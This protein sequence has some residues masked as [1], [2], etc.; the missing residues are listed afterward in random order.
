MPNEWNL[1]YDQWVIGDG[2]P[3]RRVGE[4]FD[5]F[6]VEF[7]NDEELQVLGDQSKSAIAMPDFQY[8]VVAE[9]VY[10]SE[11]ACVLDFGLR[12][13]G[14][15]SNLISGCRQGD[16]VSGEIGIGIPLCT[17][18]I[19]ENLL[20]TLRYRWRVNRISADVTPYVPSSNNSRLFVRD[21]SRIEYRK[22][23]ST[24]SF[25]AN[26]YILHCSEVK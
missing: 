20:R 7:F 18:V 6:V 10:L 23:N 11:K 4:T 24:E 16:L 9:L 21:S 19:P 5:W 2:E 8:R 1:R 12:A 26:S 15:S 17:E 22:I 25:R 14:P 3:H 13:V